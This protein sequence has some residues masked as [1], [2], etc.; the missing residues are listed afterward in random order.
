VQP[1]QSGQQL[2]LGDR[3]CGAMQRR[4][5]HVVARLAHIHMIVGMNFFAASGPADDFRV[6]GWQ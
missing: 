4:G 1:F 6:R 3:K 5:N 2:T